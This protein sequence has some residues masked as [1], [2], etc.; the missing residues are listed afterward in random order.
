MRATADRPEWSR[1]ARSF[2]QGLDLGPR[3]GVV[4]PLRRMMCAGPR[5]SLGSCRNAHPNRAAVRSARGDPDRLA[6]TGQSFWVVCVGPL[7]GTTVGQ[8]VPHPWDGRQREALEERTG[9]RPYRF[10]ELGLLR[11]DAAVR[12]RRL[13]LVSFGAN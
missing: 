2:D 1:V 13:L 4:L 6:V 9:W 10:P 3:W 11:S 12:P 7:A 8:P 5:A